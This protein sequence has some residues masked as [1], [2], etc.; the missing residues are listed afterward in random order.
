MKT[1]IIDDEKL[2]RSLL[3]S[4]LSEIPTIEV[5]G[6]AENGFEGLKK[7]N[8]LKPDLVFLDIQMPKLNGFEMLELIDETYRPQ[9][10]FSTAYDE[11]A[12]KAFEQN[13]VDYLLKPFSE[14]R[15]LQAVN[16]VQANPQKTNS[17]ATELP[18]KEAQ[19]RIV[20]KDG[21]EISIVPVDEVRFIEAQD[22]YVEI[23]A[24]SKKYLKQQTMK[25][26]EKVLDNKVF[27]R[28]H[29]KFIVKVTEIKKLEKYG[30]ETYLA[31]LHGGE[32]LNVS[33]GGYQKLKGVLGV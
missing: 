18:H 14:E 13:A 28:I 30:K 17:K 20:I 16:K 7:I 6:E 23:H 27:V 26:Y 29:R 32:Q 9:V 19:N 33:A 8:E 12:I 4:F 31:I 10:I 3:K 15:L 2:A 24:Q 21:A 25:Y 11:Y 5:I 22:D 1:I